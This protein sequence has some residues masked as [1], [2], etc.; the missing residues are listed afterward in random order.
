MLVHVFVGLSIA[1]C[2][3]VHPYHNDPTPSICMHACIYCSY[4]FLSRLVWRRPRRFTERFLSTSLVVELIYLFYTSTRQP[5]I[6][7]SMHLSLRDL[8]LIN[9][10][11]GMWGI[12]ISNLGAASVLSKVQTFIRPW[13]VFN[14]NGYLAFI[15]RKAIRHPECSFFGLHHTNFCPPD[16]CTRVLVRPIVA[17]AWACTHPAGQGSASRF[18]MPL[19]TPPHTWHDHVTTAPSA[20]A[21]PPPPTTCLLLHP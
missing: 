11:S 9:R 10:A 20:A 18:P 3:P 1:I 7:N 6:I 5:L 12:F 19:S 17:W 2:E 4:I 8:T 21:A 16:R 13:G 15:K 14:Y